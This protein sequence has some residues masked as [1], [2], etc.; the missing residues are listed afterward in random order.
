MANKPG[1]FDCLTGARATD[2]SAND[3]PDLTGKV[4]VITGANVGLG[5]E[6]A[7]ALA[8]KNAHVIL[9]C[10]SKEKALPVVEEIKKET[11]NEKVEFLQVDLASFASVQNFCKEFLAKDLALHILMN[12]AGIMAPPKWQTSTD[13]LEIQIAANHFGH[14]LLTRGLLPAL[15]RGRPSRVVVLSSY[16]HLYARSG[17]TLRPG[18]DIDF[19][20]SE[21]RYSPHL[22]YGMSKL[23]NIHFTR[24]LQRQLD[25]HGINDIYVN[26]VHPGVVR[27]NLATH[28]ATYGSDAILYQVA[29]PS[30]VGA[31]TQ[32]YVAT[33]EE[34]EKKKYKGQYFEPIARLSKPGNFA[35]DDDATRKCWEWTEKVLK[36]KGVEGEWEWA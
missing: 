2:Y 8:R 14:F 23:A 10:R 34:I 7:F 6:S 30:E 16:A 24:E 3:V 36:E 32:I 18:F 1:L 13:G 35:L 19:V 11:K 15:K 4:A 26:C 33:H 31:L 27:T 12:N 29:T 17:W 28:A 22:N 9:A 21:K 20:M 25:E 5:R